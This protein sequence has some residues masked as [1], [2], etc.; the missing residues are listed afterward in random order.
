MSP[1]SFPPLPLTS[2]ELGWQWMPPWLTFARGSDF[3]SSC[4]QDK[5][6]TNLGIFPAHSWAFT[7]I[8]VW[9]SILIREHS[10]MPVVHTD[11]NSVPFALRWTPDCSANYFFI[12]DSWI[13]LRAS[14]V[15]LF[16]NR[17]PKVH[18]ARFS[19]RVMYRQHWYRVT[20]IR[21]M[22]P[23]VGT[24]N[25]AGDQMGLWECLPG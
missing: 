18:I 7:S 13:L 9:A 14:H 21:K 11:L 22:F 15:F 19:F 3:R 17:Q 5:Y 12:S 4:S 16:W 23:F 24:E 10:P 2:S 6:F 1:R 25:V 8:K 20:E